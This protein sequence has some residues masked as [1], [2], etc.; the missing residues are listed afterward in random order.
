MIDPKPIGAFI[1]YT[2]HP[3]LENMREL[4]EFFNKEGIDIKQ[5]FKF[6]IVIFLVD[7]ILAFLTAISVT[8]LICWT[9]LKILSYSH[10]ISQ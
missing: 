1:E 9:S 6:G 5:T 4:V 8:G 2:L 7:R 10:L 3:L